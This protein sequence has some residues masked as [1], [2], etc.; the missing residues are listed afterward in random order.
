M[1]SPIAGK[2]DLD[3]RTTFVMSVGSMEEY[4][5]RHQYYSG[6]VMVLATSTEERVIAF[7]VPNLFGVGYNL[8]S[9]RVGC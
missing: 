3:Q 5:G 1:P 2:P 8:S 7:G 6:W 9:H 4:F